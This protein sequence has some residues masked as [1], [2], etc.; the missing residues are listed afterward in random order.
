MGRGDEA[1]KKQSLQ[2]GRVS[3]EGQTGS[4]RSV[5]CFTSWPCHV[6]EEESAVQDACQVS[7]V[8]FRQV[9]LVRRR[10]SGMHL[11]TGGSC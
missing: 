10:P 1:A 9:D 5:K 11:D 4:S 8:G 2:E 3:G 6:P 7:G